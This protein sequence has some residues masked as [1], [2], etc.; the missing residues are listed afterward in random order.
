MT[1]IDHRPTDTPP[2]LAEAGHGAYTGP[3]GFRPTS[4]RRA[5]MAFGV[6]LAALAIGG[7]VVL[8]ASADDRA[9]VLQLVRDVRAG[10][11]IA[12]GDL[13]IVGAD[14]DPTVPVVPASDLSTVTGRHARVFLATGSLLTSGLVQADP[15]VADGAAVVAVEIS[16]TQLP[17]GLTTRSQV[18]L[19]VPQ[20]GGAPFTAPARVV[21]RPDATADTTAMSVE[22]SRDLA[23]PIAA[24]D[25]VRVVLIEPGVDVATEANGAG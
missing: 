5:R 25:G 22:V 1:L 8:F 15:L 19:V 21:Q 3:R 6:A 13:R 2:P 14:V 18:L 7:N 16:P 12:P 10:E 23:G 24:A 4:R 17:A 9:E 20:P 11:V